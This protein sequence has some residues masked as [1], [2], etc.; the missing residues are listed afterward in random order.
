MEFTKI[1]EKKRFNQALSKEEIYYWIEGYTDGTIPDYQCAA[2]LMAIC[3]NGMDD[4]ETFHFTVAM[5]DSGESLDF[6]S[7]DGVKGDKHS[8]G[9]VGDK[10]SMALMPLV[11]SC[12]LKVAKMSGPGLGFCG[13]TVDKL[14]SIPGMN[15]YLS[16]EQ[17]IKQVKEIGIAMCG[18]TENLCPAD[19]RFMPCGIQPQ[20]LGACH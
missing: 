18:Q 8:S 16:Q 9:G 11:A 5:K 17:L 10:T 2:L 3:C 20:R 19:K 15:V 6:S 7:I 1:I 4:E 12:G 13:G 14:S